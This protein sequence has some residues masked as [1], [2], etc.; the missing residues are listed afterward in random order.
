MVKKQT[1]YGNIYD[2]FESLLIDMLPKPGFNYDK[3]KRSRVYEPTGIQ[4]EDTVET[5]DTAEVDEDQHKREYRPSHE[6]LDVLLSHLTILAGFNFIYLPVEERDQIAGDTLRTASYIDPVKDDVE[7]GNLANTIRG[8]P[9]SLEQFIPGA[10]EHLMKEHAPMCDEEAHSAGLFLLHINVTPGQRLVIGMIVQFLVRYLCTRLLQ[11]ALPEALIVKYD[12]ISE[13]YKRIY[14]VHQNHFEFKNL[15]TRCVKLQEESNEKHLSRPNKLLCY[16]RTTSFILSLPNNFPPE[17]HMQAPTEDEWRHINP[18]IHKRDDTTLFKLSAI[19]T[20]EQ[21]MNILREYFNNALKRVLIFV[22]DM[23]HVTQQ[24][25]NFVRIMVDEEESVASTKVGEFSLNKLIVILL[26]YPPTIFNRTHH[27]TRNGSFS[28]YPAHFLHGW[29]HCY[30]DNLQKQNENNPLN[31]QNWLTLTLLSHKDELKKIKGLMMESLRSNIPHLTID[32]LSR[33]KFGTNLRCVF[34]SVEMDIYQRAEAL[35]RIFVET[36]VGLV[37]CELFISYWKSDFIREQIYIYANSIF[38]NLSNLSLTDL[39]VTSFWNLFTSFLTLMVYRMNEGLNL[40]VL[41]EQFE[42]STESIYSNR[43]YEQIPAK[44]GMSREDTKHLFLGIL[45]NLS[46]PS[47]E[48]VK[49]ISHILD[50]QVNNAIHVPKFPFSTYVTREFNSAIQSSIQ[51]V[52]NSLTTTRVSDPNQGLTKPTQED[53]NKFLLENLKKNL[54]RYPLIQFIL[55]NVKGEIWTHYLEDFAY[56]N[57]SISSANQLNTREN[58]NFLSLVRFWGNNFDR[59]DISNALLKL[60]ISAFANPPDFSKLL[61]I[62]SSL[63]KLNYPQLQNMDESIHGIV[64]PQPCSKSLPIFSYF[65][66][67]LYQNFSKMFGRANSTNIDNIKQWVGVYINLIIQ[68]AGSTHSDTLE[69]SLSVEQKKRLAQMH[70]LYLICKYYTIDEKFVLNAFDLAIYMKTELK[71]G[72][73]LIKIFNKGLKK[74]EE[75]CRQTKQNIQAFKV[76]FAEGILHHLLEQNDII[77]K[78]IICWILHSANR[79]SVWSGPAARQLH[80]QVKPPVKKEIIIEPGLLT[81]RFYQYIITKFL[82]SEV[83]NA[84]DDTAV[85]ITQ[86]NRDV[87]MLIAEELLVSCPV[88]EP[89]EYIP[90]YYDVSPMSFIKCSADI[91]ITMKQ[92]LAHLYYQIALDRFQQLHGDKKLLKIFKLYQQFLNTNFF[93]DKDNAYKVIARIEKQALFQV[94]LRTYS[95]Q[96]NP[97]NS[98]SILSLIDFN[99]DFFQELHTHIDNHAFGGAALGGHSWTMLYLILNKF[100]SM[101]SYEQY[102]EKLKLSKEELPWLHSC[103]TELQKIEQQK[104]PQ[105]P[106]MN[107]SKDKKYKSYKDCYD[108]IHSLSL[109]AKEEEQDRIIEDFHQLSIKVSQQERTAVCYL[110]MYFWLA[111]YQEF[112]LQNIPCEKLY[113]AIQN[114]TFNQ[115]GL[116]AGKKRLILCFLNTENMIRIPEVLESLNPDIPIYEEEGGSV[117]LKQRSGEKKTYL[118]DF[119]SQ[120]QRDHDTIILRNILCNLIAVFIA[121]PHNTSHLF[122]LFLEPQT[123]FKT[124]MVSNLYPKAVSDTLKYDCGCELNEDGSY[125]RPDYYS[126]DRKSFTLHSFYLMTL[127]NFGA[128]SVSLVTQPDTHKY[129]SSQI[130]SEWKE[131]GVYCLSQLRTV[132]LHMQLQWEQTQEELGEFLTLCFYEYFLLALEDNSPLKPTLFNSTK[133]VEM[134]EYAIH[135]RVYEKTLKQTTE[136]R[137]KQQVISEFSNNVVSFRKWYPTKVTFLHLQH[138]IESCRPVNIK[139]DSTVNNFAILHRFVCERKRFRICSILLPNLI[140]FYRLFHTNLNY[141]ITRKEAES[142]T[143]QEVIEDITK[144]SRPL[145]DVDIKELYKRILYFYRL[146]YNVCRGLIGYGPCGAIRREEKFLPLKKDTK[147]IRLLS[148]SDEP[149]VGFDA[150]YLV[151]QDL[152]CFQ[153]WDHLYTFVKIPIYC[154]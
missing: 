83:E 84:T 150:L 26:H 29:D 8:N 139:E 143:I 91:H 1:F 75:A 151:I 65:I 93:I 10:I 86:F 129:L 133:D 4:P 37:L 20:H 23:Q 55:E 92:P 119:F 153:L 90:F 22:A 94:I 6:Y 46:K 64:Q 103:V 120:D 117:K 51:E 52:N 126:F 30:L 108:L 35:E 39:V 5:E 128:L 36:K 3:V 59:D 50:A 63:E 80:S 9:E 82:L 114:N 95:G 111:I 57:I 107:S 118:F 146:Y 142:K 60:H 130:F 31:I 33:I 54:Q 70:S 44:T 48:E 42:V 34:N 28:G 62:F 69:Y 140:K 2:S 113:R 152:V 145:V 14:L 125:G 79:Q 121:L 106:F 147:F 138:T 96:F 123:L 81:F 47:M 24:R 73:D 105:F 134:Y 136:V 115:L 13:T 40:E 124:Y 78:E 68:F 32:I 27:K 116:S 127:M 18:V 77:E 137:T 131:V 148:F 135:T 122:P 101:N 21:F 99:S 67:T 41:F 102:L 58:I 85:N 149:E 141:F 17:Q 76:H 72:Y 87:K 38:Q 61:Y 66:D 132:W 49:N 25:I 16:T 11:L 71:G 144:K 12:L 56:N 104:I 109:A 88:T 98:S 97:S 110:R 112:Y 43:I 15:I 74:V 100:S 53:L 89:T 7:V 45:K 19:R 154:T